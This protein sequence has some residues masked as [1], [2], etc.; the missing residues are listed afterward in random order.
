[1]SFKVVIVKTKTQSLKQAEQFLRN[2]QWQVFST[3]NIRDAIAAVI[4]RQPD[5]ILVAAD[6]PNKKVRVLP[7]LI[8]QA[9]PVRVIGYVESTANSGLALLHE[10][11]LEYNVYPPI[12]G[13]AIERIVLKMKK[14][15]ER[16]ES[17]KLREKEGDLS[18]TDQRSIEE[19]KKIRDN[20]HVSSSNN[21]SQFQSA[22]EMLQRLVNDDDNFEPSSPTMVSGSEAPTGAAY[23]PTHGVGAGGSGDPGYHI[24][25][26]QGM[27]SKPSYQPSHT[28][29]ESGFGNPGESSL[30]AKPFDSSW[31]T[32]STSQSANDSF[33]AS[34]PRW[35]SPDQ[36]DDM[37]P[38]N[39]GKDKT[40]ILEHDPID[41]HKSQKLPTYRQD[42]DS[43]PDR[44]S[45]FVRG[46]Q[47][48][49]DE[50]VERENPLTEMEELSSSSSVACITIQSQRF[51]GYLVAAMG[52]NRQIDAN[53]LK[54]VKDRLFNFL[55]NNGE[56]V[57][58][59]EAMDLK[60]EEVDFED[61]AIHQAEFLRK[62]IHGNNEIAMAFFPNKETSVQLE[63]SANENMLK[64]D[65]NELRDDV[66]V[67]FDL[68]IYMP[69]NQKYILYT[70]QG[71]KLFSQQRGRL[72][73][74]G[75][76]HMH[77]R[78]E[79]EGQVKRYRAQSYLNDCIASYKTRPKVKR[80]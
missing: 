17:E 36:S 18:S 65:I 41:L 33:S 25:K 52:K 61:W 23:S 11:G 68:Y 59:D 15:D 57:K 30:L 27:G 55:R 63:A 54:L 43:Y 60:L 35:N 1:M 21:E 38:G 51:S 6:H 19:I 50:S 3:T 26:G 53:F 79:S 29:P 78:K 46:T 8:G 14:D 44:D 32:S 45:I 9:F 20:M 64:L 22:R 75:I 10:C 2:R 40:P 12:S 71:R 24:Q 4:Q 67:E 16:R 56:K 31:D 58:D 73:E 77:L 72:S 7:K 13:P 62:S 47:Q 42:P 48:A 34:G 37:A 70:P 76:T 49:L 39:W 66:R 5:F 69:T 80:A 74:K 28:E